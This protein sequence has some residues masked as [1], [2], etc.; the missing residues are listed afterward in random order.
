M[1]RVRGGAL[2]SVARCAAMG[3]ALVAVVS[4]RALAQR[5]S[6]ASAA[7]QPPTRDSAAAARALRV[8]FL[9][10]PDTV[11]VGDAFTLIVTVEVP[12][13]ATVQWPV[14][15][16]TAAA[17]AMR[18][19]TRVTT[20]LAGTT[21][22]ERAEYSLAAWRVGSL[23]IA[24]PDVVVRLP[25]GVVAVPVRDAR[26]FVATVL[27]GDTSLHVPKPA[28][29]LFPRVVPWWEAWWP[30]AAVVA[31]LLVLWWMWRRR[32][33]RVVLRVAAPL[34]VF[35]RA[36]HDFDR[37]Q[38]LALADVGERGRA[39]A[40]SVEILRTYVAARIT[41]S[42][43]AQTS[44]EMLT[45]IGDDARVPRDRLASLLE[46][47]DA[48]KFAHQPVSLDRARTL[49]GEARAIVELV[50]AAE[51]AR[52]A[53]EERARREALRDA[54]AQAKADEERAR[55]ASRR[56]KVGAP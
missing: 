1:T 36:M 22:R 29:P 50:E 52:R 4:A 48:I 14:L 18:V 39:V 6:A 53:A 25:S 2:R 8:G 37:L 31:A 20:E 49:Q 27:P 30:A 46:D 44:P 45:A 9:V 19:P 15:G 26:V 23:P 10:R 13:D 5:A 56:P 32:R 21:R 41:G 47:A 54:Q 51:Q 38:R 24:F 7:P 28:R 42:T 12:V 35:A 34:D 55:R 40:L 17:V 11:T 43:L 33:A 16:D 3:L